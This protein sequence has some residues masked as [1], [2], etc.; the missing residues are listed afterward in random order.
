M[1]SICTA[2]A[3]CCT[4][5]HDPPAMMGRKSAFATG[6]DR[7]NWPRELLDACPWRDCHWANARCLLSFTMAIASTW[8][9]WFWFGE[10]GVL[11]FC[12][13]WLGFWVWPGMLLQRSDGKVLRH[14]LETARM[15]THSCTSTHT[16]AHTRTN[17]HAQAHTLLKLQR[18]ARARDIAWYKSASRAK[19]AVEAEASS[20]PMYMSSTAT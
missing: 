10:F 2:C 18:F 9:P 20:V 15:R 19:Q 3:H 1:D 12:V 7:S 8:C 6:A 13:I 5:T 4:C 16:H 17:M 14:T 11:W